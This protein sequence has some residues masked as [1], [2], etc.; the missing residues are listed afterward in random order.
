MKKW[1]AILAIGLTMMSLSVSAD[2]ARR[3]GGGM[4]FGRSAPTL[5]RS[6]PAPTTPGLHQ[7]KAN[8]AQA[9]Q[10]QRQ[11]Q[12]AASAQQP[13]PQ[14][15]APSPM[16]GMLMGMAAALGITALAHALG[17]GEGFAQFLLIALMALAAFYIIRLL[18]GLF[19]VKRMPA[20]MPRGQSQR[21][22]QEQMKS[23]YSYASQEPQMAQPSYGAAS[24]MSGSV[25]DELNNPTS[26]HKVDLPADF[27]VEGFL[28]VAEENFV[29]MQKAWD[30]GNVTSL[31]DFTTYEVFRTVTHQL[32]ERGAQDYQTEI[33]TLKSD[34]RG[35]VR[36]GDDY[37]AGVHFDGTLN[38]SG[39]A[40]RVD[41]TWILSKPVHGNGGWLLAGIH[42]ESEE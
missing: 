37:L 23:N 24:P 22:S 40:E 38:V 15:A 3:F 35:I 21:D 6:A 17:F 7:Q 11:Q 10:P 36:D 5:Q 33:V 12:Q 13:R 39:E 28:K 41:E 27:D 8:P 19:L 25:L 26:A 34:F 20:G 32:R 14:Q 16:R 4:S 18:L 29:K 31:S 2:A 9:Q 30:T 1:I 42:Q